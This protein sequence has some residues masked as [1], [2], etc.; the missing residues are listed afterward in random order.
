MASQKD[1][2][3]GLCIV[4]PFCRENELKCIA[5]TVTDLVQALET[6]LI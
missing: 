4:I 1:N 5:A 2:M 6:M 3:N